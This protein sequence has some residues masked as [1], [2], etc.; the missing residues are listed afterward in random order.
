METVTEFIFLGS[1]ITADGDCSHEIKR[2]L[3]LE[4]KAMT[5]LVKVK[6]T[7]SCLT[8]CYSMDYIV[9]G[10][11]QVRIL[12]WVAIPFSRDLPNPGIKPKSSTLQAILYQLSHQRSL[13]ILIRI[14]D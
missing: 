8:L 6:V 1:K 5:S 11:L 7:Q 14:Q 2:G 12:E 10:I 4:R 9:H 3:L 13:C